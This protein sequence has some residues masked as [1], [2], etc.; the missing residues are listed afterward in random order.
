MTTSFLFSP[1]C[2]FQRNTLEHKSAVKAKQKQVLT[3]TQKILS[4]KIS[5]TAREKI[6]TKNLD[7]HQVLR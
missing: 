7:M 5:G 3:D 6:S 2:Y 1:N 4:T